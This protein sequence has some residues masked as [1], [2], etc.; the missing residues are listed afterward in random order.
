MEDQSV[1]PTSSFGKCCRQKIVM[2]LPSL[3]FLVPGTR[4]LLDRG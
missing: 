4:K 1:E 3:D 2:V